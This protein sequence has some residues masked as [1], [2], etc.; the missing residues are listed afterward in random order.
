MRKKRFFLLVI[1]EKIINNIITKKIIISHDVIFYEVES[2]A[3]GINI[4]KELNDK[5]EEEKAYGR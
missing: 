3:R 5:N 4:L 2:W 1:I